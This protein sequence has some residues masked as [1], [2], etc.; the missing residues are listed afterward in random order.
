MP[1]NPGGVRLVIFQLADE[2][3][4]VARLRDAVRPIYAAIPAG[5]S[6]ARSGYRCRAVAAICQAARGCTSG[7]CRHFCS[8]CSCNNAALAATRYAVAS[9]SI[10]WASSVCSITAS[11][12]WL[13]PSTALYARESERDAWRS[14]TPAEWAELCRH[15]PAPVP[16]EDVA[17]DHLHD[18][19]PIPC[20]ACTRSSCTRL[21]S[22][23]GQ[24]RIATELA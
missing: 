16:D 18:G 21:S 20:S 14:R 3:E 19:A 8:R 11:A 4:L 1:I 13:L 6:A 23:R 9:C 12:H 5:A 2:P 24:A 10:S 17:P 22:A 15:A 7:L